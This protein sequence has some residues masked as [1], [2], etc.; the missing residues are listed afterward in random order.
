MPDRDRRAYENFVRA[1]F[2]RPGGSLARVL[3]HVT[4]LDRGSVTRV[5]VEARVP[6]SALPR[7][8]TPE[9]WAAL[10]TGCRGC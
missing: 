6:V 2:T 3:Q 5:M 4:R 10:W 8:L 7:D 1:V 9:Q